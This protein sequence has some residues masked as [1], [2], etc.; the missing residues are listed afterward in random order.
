MLSC[1]FKLLHSDNLTDPFAQMRLQPVP[2][3]AGDKLPTEISQENSVN[4]SIIA[5]SIFVHQPHY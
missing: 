4:A 2:S 3:S 5:Q 1:H